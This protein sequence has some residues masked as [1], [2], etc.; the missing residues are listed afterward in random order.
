VTMLIYLA[1][2]PRSLNNVT[3]A[4]ILACTKRAMPKPVDYH[5][6][7]LVSVPSSPELNH[8]TDHLSCEQLEL[9]LRLDQP[10]CLHRCP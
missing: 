9:R 6:L 10:R 8:S 7:L 1:Q 2:L 3:Q 5:L 4:S